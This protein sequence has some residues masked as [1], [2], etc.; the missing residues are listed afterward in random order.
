MR[1]LAKKLESCK[2]TA[3]HIKQVANDPQA[4]QINLMHHQTLN[5]HPA[6]SRENRNLSS[7][8]KITMSSIMKKRERMPQVHKKYD[9]YQAHTSQEGCSKY[10][11]SQHRE[12]FRCPASKHQCRNCHKCGPFSS[13]CYK[14]R[15][16]YDKKRSFETRSPKAHQ[17]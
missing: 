1:Q 7:L 8:G 5:Y 10:G 16:E 6:S 9:N 14:K 12:G 4:A 13:L 17:L 2:A 11:D 15:E 3:K